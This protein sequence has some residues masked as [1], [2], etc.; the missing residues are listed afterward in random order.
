VAHEVAFGV[1][2]SHHPT[3]HHRD[4]PL[5]YEKVTK[6]NEFHTTLFAHYLDTLASTPDGDGSLLDHLLLLYGAGMSDSN[7]NANTGLPLVLFGGGS[8]EVGGDRHIRFP[9]GTPASNL[10]LTMLDKMG[11]PV[12]RMGNSTGPLALLS[13]V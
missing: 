4:D 7:Q 5:L 12:E 13:D 10:H 2:E 11:I 3:S 6:I 8:G 1:P 9:Q